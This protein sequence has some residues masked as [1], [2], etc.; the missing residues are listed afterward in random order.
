[1]PQS[2]ASVPVYGAEDNS[3]FLSLGVLPGM[4]GHA[5]HLPGLSGRCDLSVEFFGHSY[6]SF[7][8]LGVVLGELS[9][10]IVDVVL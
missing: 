1:M 10:A 2:C 4:N 9:P 8:Q 3:T 5:Q 7:D 6:N